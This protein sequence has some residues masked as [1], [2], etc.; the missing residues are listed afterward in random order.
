VG[1]CSE[2]LLTL[3]TTVNTRGPVVGAYSNK[4]TVAYVCEYKGDPCVQTFGDYLCECTGRA[5]NICIF[6]IRILSWYDEGKYQALKGK[7]RDINL[8]SLYLWNEIFKPN[9]G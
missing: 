9:T 3:D 1:A 4:G 8:R 7:I 5:E 2:L 6:F